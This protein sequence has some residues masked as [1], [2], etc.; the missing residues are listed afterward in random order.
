MNM[1]DTLAAVQPEAKREE[2]NLKICDEY[3]R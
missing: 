2:E 1:C 3:N